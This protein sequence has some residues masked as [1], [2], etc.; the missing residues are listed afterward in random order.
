MIELGYIEDG[1][2]D[3]ATLVHRHE[4]K[5][6]AGIDTDDDDQLF[7]R[8]CTVA[9]AHIEEYTSLSLTDSKWRATL[10][11]P[12]ARVY[13]PGPCTRTAPVVSV[14]TRQKAGD[15]WTALDAGD[16]EV[17]MYGQRPPLSLVVDLLGST[18]PGWVRVTYW[19]GWAER[20]AVPA[21]LRH[22]ARALVGELYTMPDMGEAPMPHS[23]TRMLA[24]FRWVAPQC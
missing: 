7:D 16:F 20:E 18:A 24:G 4:V 23:L 22:A 6:L 10:R 1:T 12:G 2:A 9:S 5:G 14:E 13:L 8:L 3:F 15:T 17:R 21:T 11:S 19:R